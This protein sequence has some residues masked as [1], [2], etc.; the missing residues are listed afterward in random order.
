MVA[1]KS[2]IFP[3]LAASIALLALS[4]TVA[5]AQAQRS[6]PAP[7]AAQPN[8][9]PNPNS[10]TQSQQ[11]SQACVRLET[12]LRA[13][14]SGALDPTR[15][16]QAKRY[17]DA[18]NKQQFELDRVV[19]QSKRLGC[20]GGGFFS[21]F[22][23]GQ[24]AQCGPLTNQIQQM[25]GN[26]DHILADLERL[27]GGSADREGQRRALLVTLAQND[28]GPQYRTAATRSGGLFDALLGPGTI[29]TPEVSQQSST[30]RT[31]C[32]RTCDGYFFPIS[33]STVANRFGDDDRSCQRMCPAAEVALYTHRNPGEDMSQAV[34]LNGRPYTDLP[35]AFH[36]RQQYTAACSCRRAGQSWADALK[37]V[38]DQTVERGDIV[39]N[40]ERAKQLSQPRTDAQGKQIRPEPRSNRPAPKTAEVAAP[41]ISHAPA[42]DAPTEPE[43]VPPNAGQRKARQVGPTFIPAR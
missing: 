4:V 19:A 9:Q 33:F 35:N 27:K 25:R 23:G 38:D 5:N 11:G 8:G 32:V 1:M 36:Y 26:L 37:Q 24:N 30:F 21:L 41:P 39:V 29:F 28:C 2:A 15:S 42:S 40:D 14:D 22:S 12:Q 31:V 6:I 18:A 10:S 34:S 7:N 3:R 13:F 20:E 17:E 43:A 16:D